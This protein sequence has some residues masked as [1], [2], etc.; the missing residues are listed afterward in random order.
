MNIS[1]TAAQ[2]QPT[3]TQPAQTQSNQDS[4][5]SAIATDFETFLLMLTT[6]MQNQDPLN[7]LDSSD[8]AVQLATFS[9]VEQQVQT[10]DLLSD[11][12]T[13]LGLMSLS[14]MSGWVGMEARSTAPVSFDGDPLDLFPRI[15]ETADAADILVRN[16][17]GQELLRL[18][19]P[20][21]LD[22]GMFIWDGSD[23]TG[24]PMPTGLYSFAVQ[25]FAA[26][27]PLEIADVETY[28]KVNEVRRVEGRTELVMEGGGIVDSA[29]VA[30]LRNPIVPPVLQN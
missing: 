12:G 1:D 17:Q 26:G 30:A 8:F 6:Q 2:T 11:L 24:S 27:A 20:L 7:P 22:A 21:P 13:K 29:D 25:P 28:A 10:N 4:G 23:N 9:G 19:L 15:P 3:Q 5:S 18:P 14:Q 16:E